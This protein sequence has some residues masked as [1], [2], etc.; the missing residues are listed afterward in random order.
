[1]L[2][3]TGRTDKHHI[4]GVVEEPQRGQLA[5]EFLINAGLGGESNSSRRDSV[6]RQANRNRDANRRAWVVSTSTASS[7]SS[8]ATVDRSWPRASSSIPGS[9]SAAAESRRTCR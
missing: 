4:A 3:S 5:D 1:M 8:M 6:G 7:C 2:T 9:A